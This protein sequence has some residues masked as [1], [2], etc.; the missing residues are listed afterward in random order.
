MQGTQAVILILVG[1]LIL[2]LVWA[3]RSPLNRP[4]GT[5]APGGTHTPQDG[6]AIPGGT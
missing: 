3:Q 2:Y 5:A 6:Q 1:V 4:T